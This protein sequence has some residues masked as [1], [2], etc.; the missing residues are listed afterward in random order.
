MMVMFA[1]IPVFIWAQSG[2]EIEAILQVLGVMHIEEADGD[3]VER[4]YG[5]MRHPLKLN[6]AGG[7]A[8][9]ASG[10]F[11]P[12]QVVSIADYRSRHGDILSYTELSAVDGFTP[13]AVNLLKK[14]VSLESSQ[15]GVHRRGAVQVIR[16]DMDIRTSLKMTEE[17]GG[18][19]QQEVWLAPW[20]SSSQEW[21]YSSR[22]KI[23]Y[24]ETLL[25]SAS[26][27]NGG[28]HSCNVTYAHR[29]GKVVAGDFN[30]RFG[31]G[32]CLWNTTQISSSMTPSAFMKKAS[33][34]S[35]SYSFTGNYAMTGMAA[36]VVA[37]KWKISALAAVPGLK[38]GDFNSVQPAVNLVR[39]FRFG[40]VEATHVMTFDNVRTA[41]FTIPQM[42]SSVDASLCFRGVNVFIE[43]MFDWVYMVPSALVGVQ[44]ATGE[45]GEC[46]S[47]VRYLPGSNEHGAAFSWQLQKRGHLCVVTADGLYHPKSKSKDGSLST[48]LKVQ[49]KWKWDVSDVFYSEVRLTE[50]LRTWGAATRTDARLD[51]GARIGPW[52]VY[53]RVNLLNCVSLG[54]LGY[55]E[56][57]YESTEKIRC[58]IRQG[59]FR[60]DNWDDRIYVYEHD[61][62]GSFTVPAFYGRGVWTS[63]YA[64]WRIAKY[65]SAYVRCAY[66]SYP[67]MR[68]KNKPGKA[69][70]KFHLALHF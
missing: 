42:R 24:K 29:Y 11:T 10:L 67:L 28:V 23:A 62:P 53:G 8:L 35:A 21:K 48:Q 3:E 33:G 66:A 16:G 39:Y 55:L 69:E 19:A 7:H 45:Y 36:D 52:T 12:Y 20:Q 63:L 6:M 31:Q 9:E 44:S 54:L 51:A 18:A 1:L 70:L 15:E 34:L 4:L 25:L 17:E 2:E 5:I 13:G 65:A 22:G 30:A 59:V 64:K 58:Y 43:S 57:S 38:K 50:R 14:F 60:I 49:A 32:L 61:A 26:L 40:H 56:T 41:Y 37:G 68:E 46:A 27:S 47:L